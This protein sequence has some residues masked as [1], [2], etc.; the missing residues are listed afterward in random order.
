M[1]WPTAAQKESKQPIIW[2]KEAL[3]KRIR[4][5]AKNKMDIEGQENLCALK[6]FEL[7]LE[8]WFKVVCNMIFRNICRTPH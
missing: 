6:D 3:A 8:L 5:S 1:L 4:S 7:C 2:S